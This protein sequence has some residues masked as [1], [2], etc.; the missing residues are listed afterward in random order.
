MVAGAQS[1]LDLQLL[2]ATHQDIF[3]PRSFC[4]PLPV[5][6]RERDWKNQLTDHHAL[7]RHCHL[8][9][10]LRLGRRAGRVLQ[11]A[12]GSALRDA[13]V[14]RELAVR[15]RRCVMGPARLIAAEPRVRVLLEPAR[16]Q[17]DEPAQACAVD[18]RPPAEPKAWAAP[19]GPGDR[20]WAE[21]L[22]LVLVRPASRA[23]WGER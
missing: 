16:V 23:R 18:D 11:S 12:R 20:L 9:R 8:A 22:V 2:N 7:D 10:H 6:S 15:V 13:R 19:V 5:Q 4:L 14:P 21:L 1:R 17:R 3:E